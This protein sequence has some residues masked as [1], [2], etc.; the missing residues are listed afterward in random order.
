MDIGK[1]VLIVVNTGK[2]SGVQV[3]SGK[4]ELTSSKSEQLLNTGKYR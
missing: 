3:N 4:Y 2:Y 1:Y